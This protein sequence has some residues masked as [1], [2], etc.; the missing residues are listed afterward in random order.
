MEG[1]SGGD[2]CQYQLESVARSPY[3]LKRAEKKKQEKFSWKK[4]KE[5]KFRCCLLKTDNTSFQKK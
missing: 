2:A 1:N 4:Q 3:A 5:I